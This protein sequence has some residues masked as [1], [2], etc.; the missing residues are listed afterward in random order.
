MSKEVAPLVVSPEGKLYIDKATEMHSMLSD[1]LAKASDVLLNWDAVDDID[2]PILQLFY[3][4]RKEASARG[5]Q[6]RFSGVVSERAASRLLK[7]GF[8]KS[9]PAS[10]K[11]LE[12]GL[13]DF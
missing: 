5:K 6:F 12:A 10:G 7:S 13:V 4:A 8:I 11:E 2:L 1:A 3:A 9:L